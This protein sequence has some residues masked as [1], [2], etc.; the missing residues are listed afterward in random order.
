MSFVTGTGHWSSSTNSILFAFYKSNSKNIKYVCVYKMDEHSSVGAHGESC[1]AAE[2]PLGELS[3]ASLA[4]V[5]KK[6]KFYDIWLHNEFVTHNYYLHVEKEMFHSV[7]DQFEFL[8]CNELIVFGFL[9]TYQIILPQPPDRFIFY[10]SNAIYGCVH[11]ICRGSYFDAIEYSAAYNLLFF[12]N[13]YVM[14][15]SPISQKKK[16]TVQ[17]IN[18]KNS[19]TKP[20]VIDFSIDCLIDAGYNMLLVKVSF[21]ISIL[22]QTKHCDHFI[23]NCISPNQYTTHRTS[24]LS[25]LIRRVH[26]PNSHTSN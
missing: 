16:Y 26:P 5:D 22:R 2:Y 3:K 21:L 20:I 15:R 1:V 11:D 23:S 14:Y 10:Q 25:S 13:N 18:F 9:T 6:G 4:V 24:K 7:C 19:K 12:V 8:Y 17:T